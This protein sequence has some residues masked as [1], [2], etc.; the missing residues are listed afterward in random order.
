[1]TI[2]YELT[3]RDLFVG[4]VTTVFRNRMLQVF[5]LGLLVLSEIVIFVFDIGS[6]LL[7]SAVVLG[8]SYAALWFLIL[9]LGQTVMGLAMAYL[10]KER[11]L[12]GKHTIETTDEGFRESTEVNDSFHKWGALCRVMSQFGYLYV[13]VNNSAYYQIPRQRIPPAELE[14]FEGELRAHLP[15][16]EEILDVQSDNDSGI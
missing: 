5:V 7:S 4:F 11:G 9:F 10:P 14:A 8:M 13:Y 1:M 16:A 6:G 15:G 2:T 12:A 3:R